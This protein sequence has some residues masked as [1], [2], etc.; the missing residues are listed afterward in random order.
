MTISKSFTFIHPCQVQSV[1]GF[2]GSRFEVNRSN[3]LKDPGMSEEFIRR[4]ERKDHMEWFWAG[5]QIGKWLD[6]AAYTG[7]IVKDDWLLNRIDELISRLEKTQE[8][9]GAVSITQR[10]NRV[11][12]R[13]MEL[14]EYYFVLHGL[15]VCHE[16]LNSVK[17]LDIARKL[18]D[19][20]ISTWG[21]KPGQ[22]PLAGRFPG[23]GH[24]GGEGTL[25][26]EAIVLLGM[27]TGQAKYIKWGERVVARWDEWQERYPESRFTCGYTNMQRFAAGEKQIYEL[28]PGIHA[29]TFHMT[30]LGLAA[31]YKATGK[32]EYR[33]TFLGCTNRMIREWIFLT[34]G[35]SA[36]EGYIP[37]RFYNPRGDIEVCPQHTWI[38]MLAQ[39]YKWTGEACYLSEIERDLF[40]HFLAA[41]LA[42]GTNW[43]YMT[44]LNGR[45][46]EPYTPN[47]C[48]ASGQRIAARMP[49]YL[50]GLRN[51]AP[52]VL[53]YTQSQVHLN[54]PGLPAISLSQE[55]DFPSSGEI[56]VIVNPSRPAAF[57]LH[58]RIPPY[59]QG[60]TY[61]VGDG[62]ICPA[63]PG[64]FLTIE[65]EW[66]PND[67]VRLSLPF[68][69]QCQGNTEVTS[70]SRG[71]LVYAYFQTAQPDPAVY[72]GRRG[73]YP[74]D[75]VLALDTEHPSAAIQSE[76]AAAGL[77]GPALR[78]PGYV[79]PKVPMF[80]GSEGNRQIESQ[81]DGEVVLLPF[82]NQGAL[83]GDYAVFMKFKSKK[84]E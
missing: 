47:C 48:N 63:V 59:A 3:R 41:Q 61:Q 16:L 35:M 81:R 7:L 32:P 69:Y 80:A 37:R 5:E 31:L 38:L 39:A 40:N 10:R 56:T 23:N 24:G 70:V 54:I 51:N 28:N 77:L 13:G 49:V 78:L 2:L 18:G 27:R 71:P 19:Y 65:R 76:P 29:H 21:T 73:V 36:E 57:P 67:M 50:Y 83:R 58:L 60:A 62:S 1:G 6:S 75:V 82:A 72:M 25:I 20:I 33:D 8:V 66:Q 17:A 55:T 52:A 30:L 42:D 34:G 44:P 9:D 22:F 53:L 4:H 45:S 68:T 43:S 15:L 79:K 14:Y 46:Q 11:P 64:E 12:A 26:L 74:E 84:D